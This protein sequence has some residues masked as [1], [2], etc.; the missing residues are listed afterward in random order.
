[1]EKKVRILSVKIEP[2]KHVNFKIERNEVSK[3]HK[4]R[5]KP[6]KTERKCCVFTHKIR[7]HM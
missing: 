5:E 6:A 3:M 2:K 4:N 7:A 1:L